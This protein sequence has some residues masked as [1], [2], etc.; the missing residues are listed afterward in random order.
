MLSRYLR[1]CPSCGRLIAPAEIPTWEGDGF[2][3]PGCGRRLK[4]SNTLI[5]FSVLIALVTTL[6]LF[7]HLGYRGALGVGIS[8][9]AFVPFSFFLFAILAVIFPQ[10]F[11]LYKKPQGRNPP[12]SNGANPRGSS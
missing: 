6:V 8:L 2:D 7:R 9:V 12:T 1:R 3:C 5:R 10:P 11:E 4:T